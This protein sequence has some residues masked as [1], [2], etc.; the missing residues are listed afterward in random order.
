MNILWVRPE[1]F[2]GTVLL[3]LKM[4][5]ALAAAAGIPLTP[6]VVETADGDPV[7]LHAPDLSAYALVEDNLYGKWETPPDDPILYLLAHSDET[8]RIDEA[9][10]MPLCARITE[11]EPEAHRLT[12]ERY[13]AEEARKVSSACQTF[14]KGLANAYVAHQ[15]VEFRLQEDLG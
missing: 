9:H 7:T 11:L 14:A 2:N 12:L 5:C 4:R 15:Y 3:F 10:M 6:L 8:G 13:D 1:C